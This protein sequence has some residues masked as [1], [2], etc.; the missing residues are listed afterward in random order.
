MSSERSGFA[1]G[2]PRSGIRE[3]MELASALPDAIHLEVGEPDFVTPSHI[4]APAAEAAAGGHT[5]YAPNAGIGPLREA[6]AERLTRRRGR[7]VAVEQV[8]VT[9]GGTGALYSSLAALIAPGDEVLLPDPGWPNYV[10]MVTLLG[11]RPVRYR[12]DDGFLPDPDAVAHLVSPRTRVLLLNSPS[13]PVG[14]VIPATLMAALTGLAERRGLWVLSDEVYEDMAFDGVPASAC[15]ADGDVITV[16]SFSKTYA[17]TGWRVGY[18]VAPAPVAATIA[19]VQEPLISCVNTPAQMAA[20]AALE[21]PQDCVARMRESYRERRDRVLKMFDGTP[22]RAHAPAGAFYIWVDVSASVLTGAEFARSL[23]AER[24]TAVV[25]GIAFGPSGGASIRMSVAT[26]ADSLLEGVRRIV[27]HCAE[28][29][30]H[31]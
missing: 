9:N 4:I 30:G 26:S 16:H 15:A 12:L 24:R 28:P 7:R 5:G 6:L 27:E 14:S 22:V 17:M 25:P 21:G 10:G 1:A 18:A 3:V 19:K 8:V 13:N 29:A 11:A 2:M 20:L 23:I 31:R